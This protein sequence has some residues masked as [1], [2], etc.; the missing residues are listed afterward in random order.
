M[1][2]HGYIPH[3][4]VM[5]DVCLVVGHGG[6]STT[7][8]A[9]AHDLPLVILPMFDRSDQP[10]VGSLIQRAGAAEVVSR[11]AA[12]ATIRA[13]VDRMLAP[14]PHRAAAARL[15]AEIRSSSGAATAADEVEALL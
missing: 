4:M 7:M 6:H 14:G 1:E 13:A 12:P 10:L 11:R 9:L 3:A 5:T 2:V 15:G 8:Q